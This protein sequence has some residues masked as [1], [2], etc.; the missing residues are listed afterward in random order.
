M[1]SQSAFEFLSSDFNETDGG[2]NRAMRFL[3]TD[4]LKIE[5]ILPFFPDFVLID[6]FKDDICEALESYADRID[7]LKSEMNEA[8]ASAEVIKRDIAE[9]SHRLV[10]VDSSDKCC[11]CQ[12]LLLKRQFYV[13]P[14][15]HSFHADCLISEVTQ[16]LSATQLKRVL[17]LQDRLRRLQKALIQPAASGD[18]SLPPPPEELSGLLKPL[19]FARNKLTTA[20]LQSMDQ[21]RKLVI[22][23]ALV[24]AIGAG[25]EGMKMWTEQMQAQGAGGNTKETDELTKVREALDDILAS[26]CVWC[27][28]GIAAIDQ[29]FLQ[30]GEQDD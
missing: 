6:S 13:F 29:G 5:D 20:S 25:F 1:T 19:P 15:G 3:D 18:A 4:A 22:P 8:T 10:V 7:G 12:A 30:D 9:L 14:C 21:L 28:S 16:H 23:D 27:E 26:S 2:D 17:H 11:V 24:G